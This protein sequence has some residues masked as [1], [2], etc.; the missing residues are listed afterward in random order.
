MQSEGKSKEHCLGNY[1][2]PSEVGKLSSGLTTHQ[3]LQ[4]VHMQQHSAPDSYGYSQNS[5]SNT[6]SESSHLSDPSPVNPKLS[7]V[8]SE[9]SDLTSISPRDSSQN[10]QESPT[11][12]PD[13][14]D[15]TQEAASFC[16]QLQLVMKKV[17]LP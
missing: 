4:P 6:H 14:D 15:I 2:L 17:L 1:I 11:M 13:S 9:T 7:L 3:I 12:C 16:Q 10:I 8:K 5:I